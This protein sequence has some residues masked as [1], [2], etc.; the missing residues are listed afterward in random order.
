VKL[1]RNLPSF[2]CVTVRWLFRVVP[3]PISNCRYQ[4]EVH[5]V[6]VTTIQALDRAFPVMFAPQTLVVYFGTNLGLKLAYWLD[7]ATLLAC[8]RNQTILPWDQDSDFGMVYPSDERGL[9][10]LRHALE[11]ATGF[12]TRYRAHRQLIQIYPSSTTHDQ[13]SPQLP[14]FLDHT[15][16]VDWCGIHRAFTLTSGCTSRK[17][18]V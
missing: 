2:R 4:N 10:E 9:A 1:P 17:Q 5:H 15:A 12:H 8:I 14:S 16:D 7:F 18:P 3:F 11:Y 13:V 6:V